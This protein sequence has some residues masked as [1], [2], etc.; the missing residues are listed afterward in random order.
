MIDGAWVVGG[1]QKFILT[2]LNAQRGKSGDMVKWLKYLADLTDRLANE[3]KTPLYFA[4]EGKLLGIIAV[5]DPIKEDSAQAVKELQNMGIH[6]VMLTGDNQKTAEAIGKLAGVSE[7]VAGVLP[8]RRARSPWSA[9]ASTM[10][11]H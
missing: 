5:A 11:R 9:M 1:N 8:G 7:V 2:K 4:R 3:G 6:V 10:H